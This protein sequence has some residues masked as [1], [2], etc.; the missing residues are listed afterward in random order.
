MASIGI[1]VSKDWLDVATTDSNQPWREENCPHGLELLVEALRGRDIDRVVLE[2]SGGY[3]ALALTALHDAGFPVVLIQPVRARHFA[4]AL[5][6]RAKTDTID[7][8]VL[9]QMA[10]LVLRDAP[11]WEPVDD[12]LAD[13]KA[14]VDRRQQLIMQ[15]DGEK[16]RLRFAREVVRADL[17][18]AVSRLDGEIKTIEGRMDALVGSS[19]RVSRELEVLESVRGVGRISAATLRVTMPELGHL[20]RQQVASLAGVAPMNRDSGQKS[21][22]RFI[23]G[24]RQAARHGLYMAALAATRWNPIIKARYAHLVGRGK[25]PKVALVACMRKLLIHLNALMRA[26]LRGVAQAVP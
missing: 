1:D 13:L 10:M 19:D 9:A 21:G 7:A 18:E 20:T 12:V 17:E 22:Q 8:T 4:R 25:K 26:H 2:A 3:E 5:G 15:R 23:Q 6:R 24:G 14:L 11:L 16:K